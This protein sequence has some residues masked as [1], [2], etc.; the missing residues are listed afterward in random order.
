MNK[1]RKEGSAIE[2]RA[3]VLTVRQAGKVLQFSEAKMYGM[4]ERGEIPGARKI[5]GS[6]RISAPVLYQWIN[7][8]YGRWPLVA[9]DAE[10]ERTSE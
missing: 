8:R 6:W 5:G 3:G 7:G 2:P 10:V 9:T 1:H 4:L